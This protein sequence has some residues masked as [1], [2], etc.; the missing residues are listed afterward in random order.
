M[1]HQTH[2]V[3]VRENVFLQQSVVDGVAHM[4]KMVSIR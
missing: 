3:Q 4:K 2:F 1:M